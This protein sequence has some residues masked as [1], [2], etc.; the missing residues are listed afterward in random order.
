MTKIAVLSDIH[1][2]LHALKAVIQDVSRTAPNHVII[3]GDMVGRGPQSLEVLETIRGQR[4][5]VIKG[6]H[7]EF[8]AQC[9]RGDLPPE[10]Q[11]SWWKPTRMQIEQMAPAWF[12]WMDSLPVEYIIDLP[13]RPQIQVVHGSPRR[14]NEGLYAHVSEKDLLEALGDTPYPVVIGAHTH[15][16]MDRTTGAYRVLNCGSVGAPF[17]NNSAAQYLL[18]VWKNDAWAAE[19]REVQYDVQAALRYWRSSGYC[20]SGVAA[21]VFAHELETASFHFWHYVRYCEVNSLSYN[22]PASFARYRQEFPIY[23]QFCEE[24]QL[25]LHAVESL[26]TFRDSQD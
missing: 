15:Y 24:Q 13:G 20:A 21:Q 19:F 26:I 7:E 11:E 3:N 16:P 23:R 25:P 1:G 8:W 10:W 18:L 9:G 4:W 17:N 12:E 22:K 5:T 6:N 2:N 14:I